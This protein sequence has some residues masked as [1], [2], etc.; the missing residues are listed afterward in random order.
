MSNIGEVSGGVFDSVGSYITLILGI[1]LAFYIIERL[2]SMLYF[3]DSS[4]NYADQ[5]IARSNRA[6]RE[7]E[8]LTK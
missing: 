3:R 7:N 1:I 2:I 6:I 8:R 5:Q 4:M